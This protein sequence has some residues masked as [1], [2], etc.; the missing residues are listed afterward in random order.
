[1]RT[2]NRIPKG[3]YLVAHP[4]QLRGGEPLPVRFFGKELLVVRDA[5]GD[6]RLISRHCPHRGADLLLGELKGQTIECRLHNRCFA[7]TPKAGRPGQLVD[8][9]PVIER[10][11]ALLAW[12][13]PDGEAPTWSP[14]HTVDQEMF[15][16]WRGTTG[17]VAAAVQDLSEG[18][19]DN[20]HF[21]CI[22][23]EEVEDYQVA[24]DEHLVRVRYT[25]RIDHG[26]VKGLR[27]TVHLTENGP[28]LT[29]GEVQLH[30]PVLRDIPRFWINVSKTPVDHHSTQ[31]F[32]GVATSRRLLDRSSLLGRIAAPVVDAAIARAYRWFTH[33]RFQKTF[34]EDVVFFKD[35]VWVDP[36]AVIGKSDGDVLVRKHAAWFAQF[37]A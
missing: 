9:F 35:R 26:L 28:G 12:Y 27:Y 37:E 20:E 24:F 11:Q 10:N 3:W 4:H 25:M 14:E 15:F 19:V 13:T 31:V 16:P 5:T 30:A 29:Y 7:L 22:H 34:Q 18:V 36:V 1:M 32:G 33:S 21:E 6:H 2:P 17:A 8:S 23:G